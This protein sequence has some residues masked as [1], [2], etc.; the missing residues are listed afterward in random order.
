M[1]EYL[2]SPIL[3]QPNIGLAQYWAGK[4][5]ANIR[6]AQYWANFTRVYI[7]HTCTTRWVKNLLEIALPLTVF[8]ILT[9][10]HFP[11][12]SKMSAQSGENW[13]FSPLHR[14]LLYY[15]GGKTFARNR[16]ISY[17]SRDIHTFSFH[18]KIQDG[19][20]KW[21][22]LKFFPPYIGHSCT[23]RWVK[24]LLEIALPLT[25]F[26]ILT[27][28]H[29]PLKSKMSAQSGENWNFSP[30]HRTLLY[31]PGGK[32]FARNRS[33]SYGSR[34]IHTFSFHAKIQDGCQKWQKLK[35]FPLA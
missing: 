9:L 21:Q 6:L 3:G 25:V 16:S 22:K 1:A 8:E 5:F 2:A 33:I 34:D 29:F 19:C 24:N 15:P 18:A 35:F 23:T 12:K 10:L 4:I 7:G 31:Y 14:T 11:L 30:L 28:L 27:L 13:N 32:K 26:E 20:Q 17:G